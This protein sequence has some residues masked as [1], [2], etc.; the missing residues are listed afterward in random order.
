MKAI[1]IRIKARELKRDLVAEWQTKTLASFIAGTVKVPKGRTNPLA[2]AVDKIKLV[3]DE[4]RPKESA[5]PAS[6]PTGTFEQLSQG[7]KPPAQAE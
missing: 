7:F 1:E 5:K 2:K 6:N 3:H 4:D